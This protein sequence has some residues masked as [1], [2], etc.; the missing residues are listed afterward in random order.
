M[1]CDAGALF[2]GLIMSIAFISNQRSLHN[3]KHATRHDHARTDDGARWPAQLRFSGVEARYPRSSDFAHDG[4]DEPGDC[5][6]MAIKLRGSR[7]NCF[8]ETSIFS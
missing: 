7:E 2:P 8:R 3:H 5:M 6:D 1:V 4:K